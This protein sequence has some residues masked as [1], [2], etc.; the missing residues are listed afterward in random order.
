MSERNN[1]ECRICSICGNELTDFG[2]KKLTDGILCRE[3]AKKLS[4]WLSD[5]KLSEM[6]VRDIQKH[7]CYREKNIGKLN[8][9]VAKDSVIGKYDIYIDTDHR[10]FVISKRKDYMKDNADVVKLWRIR[11]I[12]VY[13]DK[14]ELSEGEDVF[15]KIELFCRKFQEMVFRVNEFPGLD[16]DS[17]EFEKTKELAEEYLQL[18]MRA[19][20]GERKIRREYGK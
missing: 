15:M 6:D 7:L 19:G 1:G 2:N 4:E 12:T 13:S 10:S 16:P 20:I 9:F 17:E 18:F 8:E 11:K 5:E 14:H 3:C